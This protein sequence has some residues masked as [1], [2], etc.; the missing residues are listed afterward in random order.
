ME[1]SPCESSNW[2][3]EQPL[4]L[5]NLHLVKAA[6]NP[7]DLWTQP[8]PLLEGEDTNLYLVRVATLRPSAQPLYLVRA[9]TPLTVARPCPDVLALSPLPAKRHR[10]DE[11]GK[12]RVEG[13]VA[14]GWVVGVMKYCQELH[15]PHTSV[16]AVRQ[17]RAKM[18]RAGKGTRQGR[19]AEGGEGAGRGRG[20]ISGSATA[21]STQQLQAAAMPQ[22]RNAAVG[23]QHKEN[24][25]APHQCLLPLCQHILPSR[26]HLLPPYQHIPLCH[27]S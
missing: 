1:P 17:G 25:P 8:L 19:Q 26:Q 24:K 4:P 12:G 9:A 16:A 11:D 20:A 21:A 22:L 10:Q 3:S 6:N 5:W 14:G 15:N 27:M 2:P 7:F 18:A 23:M 13:W